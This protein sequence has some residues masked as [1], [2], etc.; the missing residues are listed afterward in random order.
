MQIE[1]ID[2]IDKKKT[3]LNSYYNLY[4]NS[5]KRRENITSFRKI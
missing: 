1:S 4:N 3:S 2:I 5:L